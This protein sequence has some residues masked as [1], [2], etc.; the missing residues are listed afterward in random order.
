[1]VIPSGH[2]RNVQIGSNGR[3][4]MRAALLLLCLLLSAGSGAVDPPAGGEGSP[5]QPLSDEQ[6]QDLVEVLENKEQRERFLERLRT[7]NEAEQSLDAN[8]PAILSEALNLDEKVGLLLERYLGTLEGFGLQRSTLGRVATIAAAVVAVA[9]IIL[10]NNWSARALNRRFGAV[11]ERF[12][13]D[14]ERFSSLFTTQIWAGLAFAVLI[15]TYTLSQVY[16]ESL[17]AVLPEDLVLRIGET[18]LAVLLV[19]LLFLTIWELSNAIMEYVGGRGSRA[20][21]ARMKTLLPLVRN[22]LMF[23]LVLLAG[24]VLLSEL[25]I[26]VMP[27]L[28]GAG[29]LGIAIGFGAQTLVKDFLTGFTII[30]EDLVH[31]GDVVTV[32]GR[33]GEVTRLTI[34]KI[35]LRSLEG[36]V[37]TVPFSDITVVDNL[38]KDYSY[39][40][41]NVGVAYREDTDEVIQCLLE[42]DEEMRADDEFGSSILEPLEVLGVDSFG[43]S[44]VIIKARSRTRA[45]NKW[46]VG[47]EFNRRMK[48]A[49]DERNIEIPFP[50]QTLYFGED[51]AG[52]PQAAAKALFQPGQKGGDDS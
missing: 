16:I 3:G 36:T 50:H 22:F 12:H 46:T 11:R 25:G 48:Y 2:T 9:L 49:F 1:M 35:E 47:R 42:I 29:V 51:K 30:A 39:Y 10:F 37:H 20:S 6:L 33:T 38:T 26:N 14:R 45:H 17:G 13:L 27:L 43:D 32:G 40:M 23:V 5:G 21:N 52:G 8:E 44:A 41:F 15:L 31:V 19:S 24:M 18:G 7:L 4:L 34:R 28:A